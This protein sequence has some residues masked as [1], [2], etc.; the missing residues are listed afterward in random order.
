MLDDKTGGG[1][2]G[3]RGLCGLLCCE[4]EHKTVLQ[5]S[6]LLLE[7]GLEDDGLEVLGGLG[8]IG[9]GVIG[10]DAGSDDGG[11]SGNEGWT[12]PC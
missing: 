10:V 5:Y 12:A 3:G 8:G 2:G 7:D 1:G 9:G 6:A 4:V 11:G